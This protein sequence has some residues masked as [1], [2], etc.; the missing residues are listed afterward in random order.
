MAD[1]GYSA[2]TFAPACAGKASRRPFPNA[3]TSSRAD[4]GARERPCGFDRAVYRRRNVAELC[5]DR[6]K[7]WR[8]IPTRYDKQPDRYLAA[9]TLASTLIWLQ[10]R[11]T[12]R[13]LGAGDQTF[14]P[15]APTVRRWGQLDIA[16]RGAAEA[17]LCARWGGAG[18]R[19]EG[20]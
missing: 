12:R 17:G 19:T 6:L 14:A 10:T 8:G 20:K 5:F 2:R 11:S 3:S 18:T 15:R 16:S 7:Q 9:I 4:A 13:C 1:K